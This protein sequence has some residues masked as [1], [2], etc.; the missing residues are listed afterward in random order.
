MPT[1]GHPGA[2]AQLVRIGAFS[3]V[4]AADQ[5]AAYPAGT[6]ITGVAT[7]GKLGH[8]PVGRPS[9]RGQDEELGSL[10]PAERA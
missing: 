2:G 9:V 8:D 7:S 4:P 1:A 3:T 5:G 6:T 10:G